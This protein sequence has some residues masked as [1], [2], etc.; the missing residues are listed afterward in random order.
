M[1]I[2]PLT[3]LLNKVSAIVKSGASTFQLMEEETG[4]SVKALYEVVSVRRNDPNGPKTAALMAWAAEK[5]LRI[6]MAG[7]EMQDA[8][9]KEYEKACERF[10]LE[11][12]D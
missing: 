6:S 8:Y 7:R 4:I 5:T 12:K 1:S 10:P 2:D 11:G 9:R 3:D